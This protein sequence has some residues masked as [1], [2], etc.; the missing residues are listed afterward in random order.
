MPNGLSGRPVFAL[1]GASTSFITQEVGYQDLVLAGYPNSM[2][3]HSKNEL[4]L[5]QKVVELEVPIAKLF[6]L[7]SK[8]GTVE[9]Q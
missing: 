6:H 5:H 8:M 3:P 7:A 2:F 1:P 4:G 9:S